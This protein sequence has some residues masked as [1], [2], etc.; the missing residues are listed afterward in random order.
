[1]TATFP[2]ITGHPI[3]HE[4]AISDAALQG[5]RAAV[6]RLG[7]PY[8]WILMSDPGPQ[9]LNRP[10][11]PLLMALL[12]GVESV[13]NALAEN[14]WDSFEPVDKDRAAGLIKQCEQI[15]AQIDCATHATV[16][17]R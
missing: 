3:T 15:I 10:V 4:A 7:D 17:E 6:D 13:A 8:K 1:M 16:P 11:L 12:D 14:A 5:A 2:S 9:S